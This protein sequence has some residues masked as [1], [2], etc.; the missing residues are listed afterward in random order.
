MHFLTAF[1]S[2]NTVRVTVPKRARN[3]LDLR[4][5]DTLKLEAL[6]K[7]KA[8]LTNL[9]AYERLRATRKKRK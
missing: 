5:G 9:S 1:K 2:G 6:R 8:M 3:E 4:V 7:G